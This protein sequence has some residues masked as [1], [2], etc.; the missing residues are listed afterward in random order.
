MPLKYLANEIWLH[1][2]QQLPNKDVFSC[3]LVC[4][5]WYRPASQI[6]YQEIQ[7]KEN[8]LRY[9]QPSLYE[10]G[11]WT[12]RLIMTV[13]KSNY[14]MVNQ[15]SRLEPQEFLLLLSLLP[16]LQTLDL[17]CSA[18]HNYYMGMLR[19]D[20]KTDLNS[21][22][23]ISSLTYHR[24]YQELHF[25]VCY[26]FCK[27]I[28]RLVTFANPYSIHNQLHDFT[29]YLPHFTQLTELS[30]Y[31]NRQ[32]DLTI[33]DILNNCKSLTIF[34]YSSYLQ[35]PQRAESQSCSNTNKYLKQI[36]L[37]IPTITK[38]YI[39]FLIEQS[40]YQLESL[41]LNIQST[42]LYR[43]IIQNQKILS[44]FSVAASKLNSL[45]I[46]CNPKQIPDITPIKMKLYYDF[47]LNL[48]GDRDLYCDAT[49]AESGSNNIMIDIQ[50]QHQLLKFTC[51]ML[52]NDPSHFIDTHGIINSLKFI[53]NQSTLP[54]SL[55]NYYAKSNHASL[56][57]L[58]IHSTNFSFKACNKQLTSISLDNFLF[59][60]E[61][62]D[63]ISTHLPNVET[64]RLLSAVAS[65]EEATKA[66][67]DLTGFKS[68][69][70]IY[71][72]TVSC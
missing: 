11:Y 40:N 27:S 26:N 14:G 52:N 16:S 35:I 7:I 2:F 54:Q 29:Y 31:N 59:T 42:N 49:F 38:S 72:D 56:D 57:Q 51:G 20:V 36:H 4:K 60:Q 64:I 18:Y 17:S 71:F 55:L 33:F 30:I 44:L 25:A 28:Q 48:K 43:W 68:L 63:A 13:D 22:E 23:E 12:K 37:N 19:D 53:V 21:I 70:Q 69:T 46:T 15:D 5:R 45:Q 41:V 10:N 32:K 66:N 34:K 24:P 58:L 62:I 50:H 47:I 8:K 61:T 65:S 67:L 9:L 6:Y 3:M 1:I 39:Q